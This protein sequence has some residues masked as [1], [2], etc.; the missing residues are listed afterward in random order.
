[1]QLCSY[2]AMQLNLQHYRVSASFRDSEHN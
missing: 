2:A 1:M